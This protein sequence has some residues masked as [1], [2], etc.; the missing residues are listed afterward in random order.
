MND[1]LSPL[2]FNELQNNI[3]HYY[4]FQE[5]SES[6]SIPNKA[7]LISL[8]AHAYCSTVVALCDNHNML[9]Q[10][11]VTYTSVWV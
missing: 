5:C 1:M 4:L 9:L 10:S 11:V 7:R 3:V 8:Q 6:T 2:F